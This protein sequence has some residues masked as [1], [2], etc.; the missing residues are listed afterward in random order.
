MTLYNESLTV[1]AVPFATRLATVTGNTIDRSPSGNPY[2]MAQFIVATGTMTDGTFTFSF[3]E[4]DTGSTWTSV[5]SAQRRGAIPAPTAGNNNL[6][7]EV[8]IDSSKRYL[9]CI[10]TVSGG[11]VTGGLFG[12]VCV[13]SD[14]SNTPVR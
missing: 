6:T 3:E 13:L 12:A 2:E 1:V 10:A 8:G 9:R 7:Y 11:P 14:P 4:S 5:P